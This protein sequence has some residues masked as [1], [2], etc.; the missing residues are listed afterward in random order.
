MATLA[1]LLNAETKLRREAQSLLA[2]V[3]K[4][5]ITWLLTHLDYRLKPA[6]EKI[7]TIKIKQLHEGMPLAYVLGLQAFYNHTFAVT[8]AVLIPRPESE[9]I[10]D[11]GLKAISQVEAPKYFVDLG[12]GSGALIISLALELKA[13]HPAIYRQTKFFA[14]DISRSAL[15]IAR[16]NAKKHYLNKKINFKKGDLMTVFKNEFNQLAP[17]KVY[18]MANLPYLTPQERCQEPSIISEPTLALVGG[19]DGLSLYRRLLNTLNKQL[20]NRAFELIMEINPHQAA[21]L[22]KIIKNSIKKVKIKKV[23]DM[24]GRT[25]FISISKST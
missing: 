3:C 4:Q 25:R 7:Y 20:E 18:I 1:T 12:T 2:F 14:G 24:S 6:Q 16:L 8:P 15:E 11:E 13:S 23:P 9:I 22:I 5:E 10:I 21:F 19:S 17:G